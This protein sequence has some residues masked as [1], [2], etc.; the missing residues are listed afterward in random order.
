MNILLRATTEKPP[1]KS[2]V[3]REVKFRLDDDFSLGE[4]DIF[5]SV[6]GA[7]EELLGSFTTGKNGIFLEMYNLRSDADDIVERYKNGEMLVR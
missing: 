7:E 6:D 4:V 3:P 5:I 2:E 1:K